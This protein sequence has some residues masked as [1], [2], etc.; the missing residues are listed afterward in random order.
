MYKP[1]L[2]PYRNIPFWGGD[3]EKTCSRLNFF[4][5]RER[6]RLD[7]VEI[8]FINPNFLTGAFNS[9][10]ALRSTCY[11]PSRAHL[12]LIT[13][14]RRD[15]DRH[16]EDLSPIFRYPGRNFAFP[17][18]LHLVRFYFQPTPISNMNATR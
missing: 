5:P 13:C 10:W 12:C 8:K 1:S 2:H 18:E 15:L 6:D 16:I 17:V 9:V 3:G 14:E 4:P 11:C 7:A